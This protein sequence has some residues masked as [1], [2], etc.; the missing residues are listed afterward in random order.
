VKLPANIFFREDLQLM[1]FQ[2]RG[3]FNPEQV[4]AIVAFLEKAEE[5]AKH[6]FDRFS[7]L[8]KLDAVDLDFSYVF[9]ISLHRRLNY[10]GRVAVKSAFYVPN[11]ATAQIVKVHA[12]VTDHSPLQVKLFTE[13]GKAAAWLGRSPRELQVQDS[14]SVTDS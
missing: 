8:S 4:N 1:I 7:D 9:R 11:E 14:I 2:P 12:M 5:Q 13:I 10:G 6:P 3:I